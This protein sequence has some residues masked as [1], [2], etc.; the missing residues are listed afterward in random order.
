MIKMGASQS[1]YWTGP[2]GIQV[3]SQVIAIKAEDGGNI[4]YKDGGQTEM[5]V[6]NPPTEAE[7]KNRYCKLV[8]GIWYWHSN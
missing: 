5:C 8:N 7:Y 2:Y 4:L 3:P 1:E 6:L